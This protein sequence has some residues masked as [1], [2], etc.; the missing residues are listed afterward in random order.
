MLFF[1]HT[2]PDGKCCVL[3]R[4]RLELPLYYGCSLWG[5]TIVPHGVCMFGSFASLEEDIHIES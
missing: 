1:Y 4:L 5:A 2:S 3:T